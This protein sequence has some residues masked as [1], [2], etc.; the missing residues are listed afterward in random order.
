M[1]KQYAHLSSQKR[2]D[3]AILSAPN[4]LIYDSVSC[5]PRSQATAEIKMVSLVN[6]QGTWT[7]ATSRNKNKIEN[8]GQVQQEQN[9]NRKHAPFYAPIFAFVVSFF[10][11]FGPTAVRCIFSLA[12]LEVRQHESLLASQGLPHMDPSACSQFR[13]I[14]YR[15]TSAR[16]GHAVAKASVMRLLGVPP[17]P[18]PQLIPSYVLA[19]NHPGT[20]DSFSA[21]CSSHLCFLPW[22]PPLSFV[23]IFFLCPFSVIHL[24][25]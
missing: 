13:A 21:S 23:S 17:L 24:C 18:L 6:L 15:Q 4:F 7:S 16:I 2:G 10:G 14:C 9:K 22:L 20:A 8:P 5:Q 11:S 12:D 1:R 3:L 19:R 25:F